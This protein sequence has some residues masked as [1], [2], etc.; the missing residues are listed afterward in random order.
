MNFLWD[1][2][3]GVGRVEYPHHT[4]HNGN[5]HRIE[6]SRYDVLSCAFSPFLCRRHPLCALKNTHKHEGVNSSFECCKLIYCIDHPHK[7]HPRD[8]SF[9]PVFLKTK[10]NICLVHAACLEHSPA[11]KPP[12]RGSSISTRCKS[13]TVSQLIK[14]NSI[15]LFSV[16]RNGLNGT[17][18]VYPLEG[19]MAGMMLTPASTSSPSAYTILDVDQNAYLFVGGIFGKVKVLLLLF[20]RPITQN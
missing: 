1:V 20:T 6:V 4:I 17:I 3:S 12:A 19:P 10:A 15:K 16:N 8:S 9:I 13:F 7:K 18:S 11:H 14:D 5:W 2:G